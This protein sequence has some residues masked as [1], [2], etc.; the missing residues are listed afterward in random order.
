M[1]RIRVGKLG[2]ADHAGNV[3]V[4]IGTLRWADAYRL[5]RKTHMERVTIRFREDC[6]CFDAEFFARKD[7]SE[8][9][10]T[11]IRDKYLSKHGYRGRM[12]K[13]FSPYSTGWPFS[14]RMLTTSPATSDSISFISFIASMMQITL[15]FSTKSPIETN[16][17]TFGEGA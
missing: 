17:S 2:G 7:D 8:G 6:H 13:S 4:T 11:T 12:A 15:P 14:T 16:G 10:L 1:D 5:I 9:N 3:Q